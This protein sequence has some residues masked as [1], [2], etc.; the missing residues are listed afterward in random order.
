MN[1]KKLILCLSAAATVAVFAGCQTTEQPTAQE[2]STITEPDQQVSLTIN[3]P[4]QDATNGLSL[5]QAGGTEEVDMP[6][7]QLTSP[8]QFPNTSSQEK[9]ALPFTKI[10]EFPQP[11]LTTTQVSPD[12]YKSILDQA[13][14]SQDGTKCKELKEPNLVASCEF[15]IYANMAAQKND[16][17]LCK[18]ISSTDAQKVCEKSFQ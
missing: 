5:T 9:I 2:S 10:P 7:K 11:G 15:D 17:A 6:P 1:T 3:A 12:Q 4:A 14:A 16:P 13:T 18:K 8:V